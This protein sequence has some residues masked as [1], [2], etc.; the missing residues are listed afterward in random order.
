MKRSWV[1]IVS[2]LLISSTTANS[3][4]QR[5][6]SAVKQASVVGTWQGKMEEVPA[7]VLVIKEDGDKLVGTVVFYRVTDEGDG[8]KVSG[9][10]ELLLIDPKFDGTMLSFSFKRADGVVVKAQM[11]LLNDHEAVLKPSNDPSREEGMTVKM[12]R[13]K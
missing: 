4:Q 10:A 5:P 7:V 3:A 9:K 13:D 1:I 8:P 12:V 11:K 6:D 2:S